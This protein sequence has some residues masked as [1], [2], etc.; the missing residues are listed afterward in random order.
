MDVVLV[1]LPGS[2]KSVVGRRLANRHARRVHRP[3]RTHRVRR[4]AG[5]SRR[6]SRTTARPRSARSSGPPIADLGRADTDAGGPPRDR[7]RR[8]RGRRS[9]QPLGALSRPD[10]GLARR[11]AGGPRPAPAA[12]AARAAARHRPRPDRHDPGPRH[13]AG[14]VLRRG[15]HPSRGRRRGPGRRRRGGGR[16]AG[17]GPDAGAARRCS[18]PTTAIG[19]IV[20]GEGIAAETRRRGTRR[21]A[22]TARDPRSASPAPGRPSGERLADD[23]RGRR[24]RGRD[25]PAARGRGGQAARRHRDRGQRAGGAPGRRASCSSAIGGGA[26]GDAAGFLAAIYLRGIRFIQVPT[27]LVAQ[28]DSSIGGKTGVDLPEGKNLVG[29]FHQPAAVVI[30]VALPA[31]APRAPAAGRAR[32]GGQD[33]RPRRRAA[34]RAARGGRAGDRPRR[35]GRVRRP[36]S[37]P[38]S[39]SGPAWAKVE[40]VAAD[41]RERN[42]GRRPDHPQPGPHARPRRRGGGRLRRP[43][44][45]RGGRLRPA[46]RVR[47]SASR[48][49]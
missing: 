9:A 34:V 6:S 1:G 36:A 12:L 29:A 20:L 15:D 22:R 46:R 32:R 11:P 43:A 19:R 38:S 41:E 40:V 35:R 30:D 49:A 14:A 42:A 18:A 21:A 10:V 39:S 37:S 2:G 24:P 45:R 31:D 16:I 5:R 4:P 13:A 44:P 28:I 27:T 3:R 26:L 17:G 48:S 47:G 7:D 25:G 23:L 8:R 33:G